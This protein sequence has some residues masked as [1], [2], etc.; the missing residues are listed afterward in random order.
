MKTYKKIISIIIILI[1]TMIATTCYAQIELYEGDEL[2]PIVGELIKYSKELGNR[3]EEAVKEAKLAQKI[4]DVC[5]NNERLIEQLKKSY[6]HDEGSWTGGTMDSIHYKAAQAALT[7]VR[8]SNSV[9]VPKEEERKTL[10][11]EIDALMPRINTMT[12]EELKDLDAKIKEY[13]KSSNDRDLIATYAEPVSRRIKE[14]DS[15]YKTVADEKQE[16]KQEHEELNKDKDKQHGLLGTSTPNGSHTIDEIIGESKDFINQGKSE[17]SKISTS[18]LQAG[19]N[20]LYNILLGIGIVL[21]VAVGMYLGIK[22]M[23]A[24]AEDKA[25]V[26]ESLVPYIAGCVVIFGAF[27]IWKLAVVLLSG[28]A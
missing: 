22:F 23:L 16:E 27:T 26:K 12:L 20:T 5:G 13:L 9:S 17:D 21:A 14:M 24:S 10:K 2:Y 3:E 8:T 7:S 18:N 25:K 15:T 19:S 28:I 11:E 4:I 6:G 1:I